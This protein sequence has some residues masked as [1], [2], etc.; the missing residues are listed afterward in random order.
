M[1]EIKTGGVGTSRKVIGFIVLL[2]FTATFIMDGFDF[3]NANPTIIW[4]EGII[5]LG[6]MITGIAKD[7]VAIAKRAVK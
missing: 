4:A 1:E 2:G 3:Y 5:G 7:I 6:L